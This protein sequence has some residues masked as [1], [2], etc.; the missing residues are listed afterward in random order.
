[1]L[2]QCGPATTPRGLTHPRQ[3]TTFQYISRIQYLQPA[4][5]T[6][7]LVPATAPRPWLPEW[8]CVSHTR[9]SYVF[10]IV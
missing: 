1:M 10:L 4:P 7:G 9:C 8:G 2:A 3:S 6:L 5:A